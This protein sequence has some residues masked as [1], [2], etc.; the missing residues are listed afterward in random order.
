ME[1]NGYS[2]AHDGTFGLYSIKPIGR[3][4]VPAKLKGTYTTAVFA[5]NDIDFHLSK[6]GGKNGKAEST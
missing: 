3:G 1:Y 6:K 5:H 4:S 2:I